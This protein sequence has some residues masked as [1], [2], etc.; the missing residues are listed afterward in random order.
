M[1]AGQKLFGVWF[2]NY[3][4]LIFLGCATTVLGCHRLIPPL[5]LPASVD[6]SHHTIGDSARLGL[7]ERTIFLNRQLVSF[8]QAWRG[9][10]FFD[11]RFV[12]WQR[13]V[14]NSSTG[15]SAKSHCSPMAATR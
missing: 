3:D 12:W 5:G 9:V 13:I 10:Q 4:F 15:G 14:P 6:P 1:G 8:F 2:L 7:F 11:H